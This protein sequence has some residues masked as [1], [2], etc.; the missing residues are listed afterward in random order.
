MPEFY[1]TSTDFLC[2]KEEGH[3]F[4]SLWGPWIFQLTYS[5]QLHYGPGVDPASNKNEYRNIPGG[6]GWPACETGNLT[7]ICQPIV[8]KMCEP[9]NLTN[10]WASTACYRDSFPPPPHTLLILF[11]EM[12]P[13]QQKHNFWNHLGIECL[14]KKV[15][16]LNIKQLIFRYMLKEIKSFIYSYQFLQN[17]IKNSTIITYCNM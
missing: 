10:L 1:A 15:Y 3:G 13:Y 9:S 11:Q 12:K 5:F 6:K 8:Q 16:V 2:Y 4:N 14:F 17:Y 7:A